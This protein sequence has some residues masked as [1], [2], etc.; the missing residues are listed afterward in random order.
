MRTGDR[1]RVERAGGAIAQICQQR[2]RKRA[3]TSN[4]TAFGSG[5][6]LGCSLRES[7]TATNTIVKLNGPDDNVA[8]CEAH[9]RH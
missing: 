4:S 2:L 6:A 3:F 9:V 8:T 1:I 7:P 5:A